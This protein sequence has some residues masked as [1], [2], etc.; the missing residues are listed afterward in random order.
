LT[1]TATDLAALHGEE[2]VAALRR[3]YDVVDA[4]LECKGR[5]WELLRPRSAESMLDEEAFDRDGRIPYWAEV[6]PSAEILAERIAS[7]R[8]GAAGRTLLELG[9]G[10]GLLSLVAADSGYRSRNVLASDYYPEALD[11]VRANAWLN[12]LTEPR[13]EML[14]WRSLP[15][16]LSTFDRVVAA[17]VLYEPEHTD[18]VIGAILRTLAA[19][20]IA[21][22]ADPGRPTAARFAD[23]CERA[24]LVV[25]RERTPLQSAGLTMTIDVY[26]LTRGR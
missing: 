24:G 26:S 5:L 20:G 18:L 9:C 10:V 7:E 8:R 12:G 17:D 1:E 6:W 25:Q 22:V 14:D 2:L 19:D 21:M 4:S 23:R 11:F 15:A 13:T 3:R 16:D